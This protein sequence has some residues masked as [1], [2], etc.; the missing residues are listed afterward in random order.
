MW[1]NEHREEHFSFCLQL[2]THQDSPPVLVF[3]CPLLV[4]S[5]TLHTPAQVF[6]EP[7][8]P[9]VK[10]Q[11]CPFNSCVTSSSVTFLGRVL[12]CKTQRVGIFASSLCRGEIVIGL[13]ESVRVRL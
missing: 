13:N 6:S 11:L 3:H 1:V 7:R 2:S 4:G 12:I 5:T 10:P 9:R 8:P